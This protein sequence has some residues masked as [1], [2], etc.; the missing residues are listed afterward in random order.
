MDSGDS[1][2]VGGRTTLL[3]ECGVHLKRSLRGRQHNDA[4]CSRVATFRGFRRF[5]CRL[6]S[7]MFLDTAPHGQTRTVKHPALCTCKCVHPV[8][9]LYKYNVAQ[10]GMRQHVSWPRSAC[11]RTKGTQIKRVGYVVRF[12]GVGVDNNN[13]RCSRD[14]TAGGLRWHA[15]LLHGSVHGV[16]HGITYCS[17]FCWIVL[18][19]CIHPF[20]GDSVVCSQGEEKESS[21]KVRVRVARCQPANHAGSPYLCVPPGVAGGWHCDGKQGYYA[22]HTQYTTLRARGMECVPFPCRA[23]YGIRST[24]M[25]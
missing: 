10:E 18:A 2:H 24:S 3:H 15:R 5:A 1:V 14:A 6:R 16:Q 7:S 21:G 11:R 12:H 25:P 4:R 13:A 20:F 22:R 23:L 17:S 19:C 9:V 8:F